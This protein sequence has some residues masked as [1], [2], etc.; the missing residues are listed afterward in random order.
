MA[1]VVGPNA[2]LYGVSVR[3]ITSGAGD[4][5][6]AGFAV[7]RSVTPIAPVDGELFGRSATG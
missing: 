5:A 6:A 2:L 4:F 1:I 3:D 7:G